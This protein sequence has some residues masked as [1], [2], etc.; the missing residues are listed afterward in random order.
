MSSLG[1]V[2]I[3]SIGVNLDVDLNQSTMSAIQSQNTEIENIANEVDHL[4]NVIIG[5]MGKIVS[6]NEETGETT[7]TKTSVQDNLSTLYEMIT[8]VATVLEPE[9][10]VPLIEGKALYDEAND[11]Y[12][13]THSVYDAI[14]IFKNLVGHPHSEGEYQDID[15]EGNLKYLPDGT[16]PIYRTIEPTGLHKRSFDLEKLIYTFNTIEE[17]RSFFQIYSIGD[18]KT[19]DY[20]NHLYIESED[21]DGEIRFKTKDAYK[22]NDHNYNWN[23]YNYF[24]PIELFQDSDQ[25]YFKD[26]RKPNPD[27]LEGPTI[28][29]ILKLSLIHI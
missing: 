7:E 28:S 11:L 19:Y 20:R 3:G 5:D 9:L 24:N 18:E 13:E 26:P 23:G 8:G 15:E 27:D 17:T 1:R 12:N 22:Y 16:T 21:N 6:I 14:N 4:D 29:N 10:A 2:S 25:Y